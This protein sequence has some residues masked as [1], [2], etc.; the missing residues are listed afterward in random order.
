MSEF[1]EG[2]ICANCGNSMICKYIQEVMDLTRKVNDIKNQID[3]PDDPDDP[4]PYKI[5]I[6]C[7]YF[8]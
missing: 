7:D 6:D 3:N 1:I 8:T 2:I 5:E 4:K